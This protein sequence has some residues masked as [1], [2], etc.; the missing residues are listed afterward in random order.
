MSEQAWRR[1]GFF[2]KIF[3]SSIGTVI[4]VVGMVLW[5]IYMTETK[6]HPFIAAGVPITIMLAALSGFITWAEW[7]RL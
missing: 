1:V 4:L 2:F 7:N 3:G 6:H 5:I